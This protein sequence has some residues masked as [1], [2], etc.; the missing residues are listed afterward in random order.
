MKNQMWVLFWHWTNIWNIVSKNY[1]LKI[2]FCCRTIWEMAYDHT[3]WFASVGKNELSIESYLIK[4]N[5]NIS[6]WT[7]IKNVNIRIRINMIKI[8]KSNLVSC[9]TIKSVTSLARQASTNWLLS[10]FPLFIRREFGKNN[11]ISWWKMVLC[12]WQYTNNKSNEKLK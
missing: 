9:K 3:I 8:K 7:N 2:E 5:V 12:Y 6:I 11:F 4:T 1:I 10:Y